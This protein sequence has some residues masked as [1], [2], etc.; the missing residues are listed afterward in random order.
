MN[1]KIFFHKRGQVVILIAI[2]ILGAILAI[3]AG[4]ITL[5]IKEMR[6]GKNIKESVQSIAA[7][8]AGMEYMEYTLLEGDDVDADRTCPNWE[9]LSDLDGDGV[10]DKEDI[11][12]CVKKLPETYVSI[13]RS[14]SVRRAIQSPAPYGADQFSKIKD[15]EQLWGILGKGMCKCTGS[16]PSGDVDIP[17]DIMEFDFAQTFRI[18]RPGTLEKIDIYVKA[19][20]GLDNLRNTKLK[21]EI[22]NVVDSTIYENTFYPL[23]TKPESIAV[24]TPDPITQTNH[25]EI[26]EPEG[27]SSACEAYLSFVFDELLH[28]PLEI[29]EGDIGTNGIPYALVISYDS[30]PASNVLWAACC[31]D[32]RYIPG[33]GWRW[34]NDNQEWS[35]YVTNTSATPQKYNFDL[36]FKVY[37]LAPPGGE[38]G[39]VKP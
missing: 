26:I 17:A 12:Y 13:G 33:K 37:V 32:R 27:D 38:F 7:A 15:R 35:Q 5:T 19:G 25:F 22:R 16:G 31:G 3:S 18:S 24:P 1:S 30:G 6:M 29:V 11:C 8:D 14:G 28:P 21:A 9:I 10:C 4:L 39:E 23:A 36:E 2:L 34:D 20:G